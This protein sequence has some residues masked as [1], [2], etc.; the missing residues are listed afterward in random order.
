[1]VREWVRTGSIHDPSPKQWVRSFLADRDLSLIGSFFTP[2][3][4][5]KAEVLV[6]RKQP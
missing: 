3:P 4:P 1:M 5:G 6:F 2:L